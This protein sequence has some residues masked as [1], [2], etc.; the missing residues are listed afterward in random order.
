[1]WIL[2]LNLVGILTERDVLFESV[3]SK[4][5]VSELMTKD[6]ISANENTT[7][8]SSK[9]Y[10]QKIKELKNYLL[11]NDKNQIVGSV[12]HTRH[13]EYREFS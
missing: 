1:M 9:R 8:R 13:Y 4:K 12:H 11:V 5:S 7:L 2:I 3:N 6:V 10:T